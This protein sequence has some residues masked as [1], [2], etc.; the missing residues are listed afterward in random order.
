M[1]VTGESD[2]R[3]GRIL[4]GGILRQART[5]RGETQTQVSQR[6]G[7]SAGTLSRYETGQA[8]VELISVPGLLRAYG[9]DD[10]A[11]VERAEDLIRGSASAWW[12]GYRTV[13]PAGLE[14]LLRMEL[15]ATRVCSASASAIE[16]LFQTREY[17]TAVNE[18][19]RFPSRT[20]ESS[21]RRVDLRTARQSLLER[22]IEIDVL[23]DECVLRRVV[24][25]AD[26][27][28]GQLEHLRSL[29]NRP[30]MT[31]RVL[32]F[33]RGAYPIMFANT[34]ILEAPGQRIVYSE[35]GLGNAY[36][37]EP[38][39]VAR[40]QQMFARAYERALSPAVTIELLTEF[41]QRYGAED[42]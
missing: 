32:P 36:L 29:A 17:A 30:N 2:P 15:D 1:H 19:T 6:A 5:S 33:D 28:T 35:T 16:G 9:V 14:L 21:V 38:S 4:F 26:V 23:L 27:M 37:S 12:D 24:G 18:A 22:D 8:P 11:V 20:P 41:A 25:S 42:R 10:P 3:L 31:V 39:D 7:K 13:I 40:V 34:T